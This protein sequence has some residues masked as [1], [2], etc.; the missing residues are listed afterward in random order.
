MFERTVAFNRLK[1]PCTAPFTGGRSWGAA[2]A[3]IHSASPLL[4]TSACP[5]VA[6][7]ARLAGRARLPAARQHRRSRLPES[8]TPSPDQR[9]RF[10]IAAIETDTDRRRLS[11]RP[12]W[13]VICHTADRNDARRADN[14][15]P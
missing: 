14:G 4:I 13:R 9:Q 2:P 3:F 5:S 11:Y 10:A 8:V 7:P 6:V 1:A 12:G 15:K